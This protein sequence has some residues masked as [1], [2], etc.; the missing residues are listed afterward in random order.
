MGLLSVRASMV[1][2]ISLSDKMLQASAEVVP[3][4]PHVSTLFWGISAELAALINT[5]GPATA[6]P[7][8]FTP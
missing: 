1:E 7:V 3:A 6:G 5:T 2:S 8:V 4:T